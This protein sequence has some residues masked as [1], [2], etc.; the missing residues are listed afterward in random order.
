M[1]NLIKALFLE[2][3]KKTSSGS[4]LVAS[5]WLSR[6]EKNLDIVECLCAERL[7]AFS[8]LIFEEE[9]KSWFAEKDFSPQRFIEGSS[10]FFIGK[11][12]CREKKCVRVTSAPHASSLAT[13]FLCFAMGGSLCIVNQVCLSQR[14]VLLWGEDVEE[15]EEVESEE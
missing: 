11:S 4:P 13:I 12:T 9:G 7:E 6:W 15:E 14:W 8:H 3:G 1:R 5:V 10:F 2:E